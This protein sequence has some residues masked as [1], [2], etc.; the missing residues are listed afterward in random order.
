MDITDVTTWITS[1]WELIAIAVLLLDKIVALTPCQWDDLL[2]TG[3]K[4][5]LFRVAGKRAAAWLLPFVL[6]LPLAACGTHDLSPQEAFAKT[7]YQTLVV[8][9]QSYDVTMRAAADAYSAGHIDAGQKAAVIEYG[10]I[11]HGVYHLA[12]EAL[13]TYVTTLRAGGDDPGLYRAAA[14]ALADV[15]SKLDDLITYARDLGVTLPEG[16]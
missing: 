2:W 4:K 11:F 9:G 5:M 13:D 1:H 3:I 14:T 7:G 16:I 8:A 12:R 6:L 15:W 10:T